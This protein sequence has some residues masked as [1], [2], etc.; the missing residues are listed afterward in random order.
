MWS[1]LA[2]WLVCC[3][4]GDG[5]VAS[6]VQVNEISKVMER[7]TI[8]NHVSLNIDRGQ[9]VALCGGNGAGK[10]TLLRLI[11][12]VNQPTSGSITIGDW[13]WRTNR[14]RYAEQIGYM[15]DDFL[16]TTK[17]TA[18]ETLTFW[19]KLRGVSQERVAE[20]LQLVGLFDKRDQLVPSFSKGMRQRLLF[21]QAL[22]AEPALLILDE[23][24][25]GLDPY[26]MQT[27]EHLVQ[28][29]RENGQ[30]VLF[31]THQIPIAERVADQVL[32]MQDGSLLTT[33]S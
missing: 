29:V 12:G 3:G 14:Q 2:F 23:P 24:T 6:F 17:L 16:F 21:G 18:Q 10:S 15:P 33:S 13:S 22:L 8:L 5:N 4:K 19:A 28:A 11:A 9:I 25:N 1:L 20:V 26:W 30:T 27:F 32:Y 7:K 31:S